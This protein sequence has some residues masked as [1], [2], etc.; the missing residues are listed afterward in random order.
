MFSFYQSLITGSQ[1]SLVIDGL[2]WCQPPTV[3][4][5]LRMSNLVVVVLAGELQLWRGFLC[6]IEERVIKI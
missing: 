4:P 1:V 5:G 2:E 6:E 3:M